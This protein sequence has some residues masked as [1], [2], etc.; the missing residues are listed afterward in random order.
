MKDGSKETYTMKEI[1]LFSIMQLVSLL[2][3]LYKQHLF[4]KKKI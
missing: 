1:Y 3:D 4:I 2:S